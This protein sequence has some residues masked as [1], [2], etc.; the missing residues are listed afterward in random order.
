[1]NSFK[2]GDRV[3]LKDQY[4]G[5]VACVYP[6]DTGADNVDVDMLDGPDKGWILHCKPEDLVMI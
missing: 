6:P 2:Q 3:I 5:V 4:H 1:V